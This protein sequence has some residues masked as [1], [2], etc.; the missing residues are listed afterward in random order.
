MPYSLGNV[1]YNDKNNHNNDDNNNDNNDDWKMF[2]PI[3]ATGPAAASIGL[4]SLIYPYMLM[5]III[6]KTMMMMMVM[7]MM[8]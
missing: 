5:M 4:K 2:K 3:D 7:M 8:M 6:I 1:A